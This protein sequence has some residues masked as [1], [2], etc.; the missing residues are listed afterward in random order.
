MRKYSLTPKC[1]KKI[2]TKHRQIVTKL[3]VPESLPVFQRLERFEPSSM[4]GQPPIL[5]DRAEGWHV[6]D[7]WGNQWLDWSSGVLISNTGNSNPA[8]VAAL[9]EMLEKPLLSTY[10]FS[11]EKRAELAESLVGLAPTTNYKAFLLSTGSEATENCIKL[12]R[13]TAWSG[14]AVNVAS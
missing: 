8:I 11:H 12:A 5:I 3:P 2:Q 9:R 10:V 13:P 14:T 4:Q 6:F 1:V 7:R